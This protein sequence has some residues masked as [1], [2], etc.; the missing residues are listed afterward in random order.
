LTGN[1]RAL[2]LVRLFLGI[3]ILKTGRVPVWHGLAPGPEIGRRPAPKGCS[4]MPSG[5]IL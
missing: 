3:T 4:K 5:A 1:D 2:F